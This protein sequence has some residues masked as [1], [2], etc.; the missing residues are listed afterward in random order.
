MLE[1]PR[2]WVAVAFCLFVVLSYKKV[3]ALLTGALDER[4]VKIK[5][6]L[7]E[8]SRLR[9]EA[10]QLLDHYKQKQAE[11]MREAETIIADAVKDAESLRAFSEQELKT[12]MDARMKSAVD[13]IAQEESNAIAEVRNH[14]VDIALSAA[15]ALIIDHVSAMPHEELV[16][17]ALS[18]IERKIH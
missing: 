17:L 14:V 15:R 9:A 13:R 1:D 4:S 10:Q 2:F 11:Y 8:A 7:D 16:K 5:N 3:A 6:E 18:D 12:T